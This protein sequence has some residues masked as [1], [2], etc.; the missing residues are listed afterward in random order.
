MQ[1]I[2]DTWRTLQVPALPGFCSMFT[3]LTGFRGILETT[4]WTGTNR[5][6]KYFQQK[7]GRATQRH[8]DR[9]GVEV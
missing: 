5:A 6:Y 1:I 4:Q 9:N 2:A 3:I 8:L 7:F